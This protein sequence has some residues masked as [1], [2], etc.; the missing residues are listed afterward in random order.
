[1]VQLHV[2]YD[3]DDDDDDDDVQPESQLGCWR[4]LVYLSSHFESTICPIID[5]VN[6]SHFL[7]PLLFP[8]SSPCMLHKTLKD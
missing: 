1:M 6:P 3:D 5:V 2:Y 7:L 4:R 8:G